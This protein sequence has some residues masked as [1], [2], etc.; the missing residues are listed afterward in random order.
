MANFLS[1]SRKPD[2]NRKHPLPFQVSKNQKCTSTE[3][4]HF[5]RSEA[6]NE[7][8]HQQ[9]QSTP[10]K[11]PNTHINGNHP[12]PFLIQ[13]VSKNTST[14]ISH[15]LFRAAQIEKAHQP[16]L[17]IPFKR[18]KTHQQKSPTSCLGLQKWKTNKWES[19]TFFLMAANKR[20]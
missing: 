2:I 14:E 12:L 9:K 6:K 13:N 15:F 18:R 10:L 3:I 4:P 1:Q 8:A 19:P 16:K 11:S 17:A 7:K 20:K 5:L